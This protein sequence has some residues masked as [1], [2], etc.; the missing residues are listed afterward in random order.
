[1]SL[2]ERLGTINRSGQP[3]DGSPQAAARFIAGQLA[4]DLV[5]SSVLAG[6]GRERV[7]AG[8]TREAESTGTVLYAHPPIED[9]AEAR[10]IAEAIAGQLECAREAYRG[11]ELA[12]SEMDAFMPVTEAAAERLR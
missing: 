6:A 1:M 9:A 3:L 2:G 10:R 4:F 8:E 12:S 11:G 7:E 5:I